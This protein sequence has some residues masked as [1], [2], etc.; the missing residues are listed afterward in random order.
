M[1]LE[2]K[3]NSKIE[4]IAD[5]KAYKALIIDV[6][7]DNIK[8]N[9]PVS[10]DKYL[11][12]YRNDKVEINSYIEDGKCFNYFCDVISKG[13]ENNVVYYK[14][15]LPYDI[16]RIQRRDFFRVSLVEEVSYKNI[17]GKKDKE[18]EE[19]SYKTGIMIDLSASGV[20]IK[21][22]EKLKENDIIVIKIAMTGIEVKLKG[23]I[24]RVEK[25]IDKNYLCGI[26]FLDIT[27]EESDI[28]IRELFEISRKQRSN[29]K[30]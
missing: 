25:T 30:G 8:I 20:K 1:N 10:N 22:K 13:R 15:T 21:T 29:I 12:L 17:T 6:E 18:I 23:K 11:M 4:V 16:T 9:V 27:E 7:D 24:V 2:L 5:G 28:I 3:V 14:L 19:M 26:K